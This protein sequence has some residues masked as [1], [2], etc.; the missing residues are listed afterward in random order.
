MRPPPLA[1]ALPPGTCPPPAELF[2]VFA[3]RSGAVFL[4]SALPFSG[5][6]YSI[7][8]CEPSLVLRAEPDEPCDV[9]LDRLRRELTARACPA[10]PGLPFIGGAI[11]YLGYEAGTTLQRVPPRAPDDT[12][13]P[14]A[15]FAF[16]DTALVHDHTTSLTTL[17]A[18]DP[19]A[20]QNLHALLT[21]S[22]PSSPLLA[23][24][25]QLLA[26]RSPLLAP[27][28]LLTPAA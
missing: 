23:P 7:L 20:L 15:A 14:P 10:T 21:T 25:A 1:L 18:P 13:L 11:G 24:P 12:A 5:A 19:A 17:V 27:A 26:P 9:F 3:E 22:T 2:P 8:C 16:Y 28:P 4:D 6:R